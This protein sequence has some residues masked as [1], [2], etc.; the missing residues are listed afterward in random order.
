MST[1]TPLSPNPRRWIGLTGLAFGVFATVLDSTVLTV[2]I[3]T[4]IRDLHAS[5]AAV[6]WVIAG[7]SL[8]FASLLVVCGR[9][10]DLFGHRRMVL[11]GLVL[12]AVGALIASVAH[13][14]T[15]LFVGDALIEGI[16][17][18]M[19]SSSSLA[20]I[21]NEFTGK[22]RAG[23]F[24]MFGGLAGI[25]GAF[26][27]VVGGWLTSDASWRWAFRINVFL[28]PILIALILV[29]VREVRRSERRPRI[30]LPGGLS[31]TA[32]LFFLVFGIIEAPTYGWWKP[33]KPFTLGGHTVN[34]HG[35]SDVPIALA[36]AAVCL[37]T[38]ILVERVKDRRHTEPLFPFSA[39][40]YRSF[41]V[42]VLTTGLL[43][44]GEFT[45]F[46]VLSL[47]LQDSR[48]LSALDTGLWILPFGAMAIVGAG[49]GIGLAQKLGG[50]RTVT[51]GMALETAGLIWVALKIGPHVTL[52]S[53]I[54]AILS[55]GIGIGFATAQLGNVT[56]AE[57]PTRIAGVASGANNTVRQ[58]GA[59]LGIAV[60]GAAYNGGGGRPAV[61]VAAAAVVLG[62]LASLL[63]PN[64]PPAKPAGDSPIDTSIPLDAVSA[65]IALGRGVRI[66]IDV[67]RVVRAGVHARLAADAALRVEV[68]DAVLPLVQRGDRTHLHARSIGAV[69]AA[70][71]REVTAGVGELPPLDVLDPG[72]EHAELHPVLDLAGDR[73][74]V[75]SDAPPLVNHERELTHP[76]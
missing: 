35:L 64:Q 5:V 61:L 39:L 48:H 46:F 26:G 68:H 57:I 38:F 30:D 10:G 34:P 65:E 62:T 44:A 4:L 9:F 58:V 40:R 37:A 28:A 15:T 66:G 54:P 49:V 47:V 67:Q 50:A 24:G 8:V 63:I 23:A 13:T 21:S 76:R 43:A 11:G 60:V 14:S 71:H 56:L 7:Y 73:A 42:G 70:Q 2:A 6:Q 27:P 17:A 1:S 31:V 69:V 36:L 32:G 19:M 20:L 3:P 16:G 59:A 12:F 51:I 18:A 29:G 22:E 52:P 53:L 41:H 55:Y 75:A 33:I 25:A 74:G 45:M 72:P